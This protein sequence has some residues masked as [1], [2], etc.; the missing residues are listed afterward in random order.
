MRKPKTWHQGQV[1]AKTC[2]SSSQSAAGT[3]T[4]EKDRFNKIW[5]DVRPH[6][7]YPALEFRTPV[8]MPG[9]VRR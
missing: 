6:N 2:H 4:K 9:A 5:R 1:K 3:E 8:T 7:L